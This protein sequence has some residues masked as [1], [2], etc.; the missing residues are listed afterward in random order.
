MADLR[1]VICQ[2]KYPGHEVRRYY[3]AAFVHWQDIWQ[4]TLFELEGK[5]DPVHSDEFIQQNEVNVLWDAENERVAGVSLMRWL[6][7]RLAAHRQCQYFSHF[8]ASV[9]E[10]LVRLE[11]P[12]LIGSNFSLDPDYRGAVGDTTYKDL[13]F[14][15]IMLRMLELRPPLLVGTMRSDRGMSSMARRFGADVLASHVELHYVP[16]DLVA[17]YPDGLRATASRWK[18]KLA[19][20]LWPKKVIRPKDRRTGVRDRRN[21][22]RHV[23]LEE[24]LGRNEPDESALTVRGA[25]RHPH[26]ERDERGCENEYERVL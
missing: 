14:S 6:D 16:V 12:I 5:T 13:F 25:C 21:F 8:P 23:W 1:F 26:L 17:F 19:S 18:S 3:D 15:L 4:R 7:L 2:S 9:A 20:S 22:S 10:S 24:P 11:E